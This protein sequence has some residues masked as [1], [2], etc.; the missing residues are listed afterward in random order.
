MNQGK[1][2]CEFLK[3]IRLQ[4]AEE[5]NIP[6]TID[7]CTFEGNCQGTCPRCEAELHYL[8]QKIEEKKWSGQKAI[9]AGISLGLLST[10]FSCQSEV[11]KSKSEHKTPQDTMRQK[12]KIVQ[13]KQINLTKPTDNQNETNLNNAV[14]GDVTYTWG[15]SKVVEGFEPNHKVNLNDFLP[16]SMKVFKLND[17][18]KEK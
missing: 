6:L 1:S 9:V 7:E 12:E 13:N 18:I 15:E 16:D 3:N 4:I 5:N 14:L 8:E 10:L 17:W 2:N 11:N